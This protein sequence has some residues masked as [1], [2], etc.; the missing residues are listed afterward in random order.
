MC[1]HSYPCDTYCTSICFSVV[2]SI[3]RLGAKI[4]NLD[5]VVN[6]IPDNV[7]A[8]A[9]VMTASITFLQESRTEVNQRIDTLEAT[10]VII[11][12]NH[13]VILNI[14]CEVAFANGISTD[15]VSKGEKKQKTKQQKDGERNMGG[16]E[17]NKVEKQVMKKA[18]KEASKETCKPNDN[19]ARKDDSDEGENRPLSKRVRLAGYRT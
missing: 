8:Q 11:L 10:Q 19:D 14:L 7:K 17:E 4:F 1:N 16:T 12:E 15:D 6:Q 9:S 2:I 18:S 3:N 13:S 5:V